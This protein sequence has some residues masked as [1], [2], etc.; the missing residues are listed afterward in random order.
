LFVSLAV[1][2]AV[3]A[4]MAE[5]QERFRRLLPGSNLRWTRHEQ[6]HL[7]LRFLGAVE[8]QKVG[9]MEHELR[10]AVASFPA[11]VLTAGG[12]GCF[13]NPRRPRVLWVGVSDPGDRLLALQGAVESVAGS[14]SIEPAEK[15]FT[16][17]LTLARIQL[18]SAEENRRLS[19]LA[20]SCSEPLGT[21]DVR[22]VD[23]MRSEL[24]PKGARH[25]RLACAPLQAPTNQ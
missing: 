2:E 15:R 24:S 13:P 7:T 21:W 4:R 10:L 6:F 16:G 1:P 18:L 3:K 23:L 19:D 25:S 22:T 8:A 14:Y 12:I 17:H 9:A 5:T 11:F 20:A